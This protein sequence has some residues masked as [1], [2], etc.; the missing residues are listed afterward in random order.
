MEEIDM[1]D[2]LEK[3]QVEYERQLSKGF[4]VD[5][6]RRIVEWADG[7]RE[8]QF[9][10]LTIYQVLSLYFQCDK[11]G[12]DEIEQLTGHEYGESYCCGSGRI[13]D[14]FGCSRCSKCK[15]VQI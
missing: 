9:D 2:E 7:Q 1:A 15:G 10:G 3:D 12:V 8:Y 11:E 5:T 4:P 14:I 6:L 13:V